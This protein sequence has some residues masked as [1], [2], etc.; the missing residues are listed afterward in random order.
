M[1]QVVDEADGARALMWVEH[2]RDVADELAAADLFAGAAHDPLDDT[3]AQVVV[4]FA[5]HR[6]VLH[7]GVLTKHVLDLAGADLVPAALDEVQRAAA[8]DM[9]IAVGGACRQ[10]ARREPALVEGLG[11]G[12][13]PAEVL[14]EDVRAPYMDLAH[15]LA[16]G[17]VE[18][19]AAIIDEP[20]LHAM[21]AAFVGRRRAKSGHRRSPEWCV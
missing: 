14:E 12:V 17:R 7:G 1:R 21:H 4:G 6:N 10:V 13:R 11:R 5:G 2:A 9:Q 3:L 15:R 16:I 19:A 20:H 18:R 8:D